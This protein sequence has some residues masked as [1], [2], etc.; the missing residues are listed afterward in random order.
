[1]LIK[2]GRA[3]FLGAIVVT[4]VL[5]CSTIPAVT[6]TSGETFSFDIP[7]NKFRVNVPDLPQ[8]SMK[9]HPLAGSR[10]DMRYMG[11]DPKS[12][13]SISILTPTADKGM[14]P[15]QCASSSFGSLIKRYGLNEKFV[16][17]R[18]NNPSTYIVLFPHRIG[19]LI[20]LKA[21]VLSGYGG[22]HCID[23]HISKNASTKSEE[24][25]KNQLMSWYQ[26]FT[27]ASIEHY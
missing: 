22:D 8:I 23:V 15:E 20:Q 9:T 17:S 10:P 2:H 16:V 6:S 27:K 26:S 24:E 4:A 25:F 5:G 1:M 21:Y 7:E 12:G 3:V 13:Y 11:E 19:P 18:K 14:T